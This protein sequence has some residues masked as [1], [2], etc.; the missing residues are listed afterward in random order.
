MALTAGSLIESGDIIS[1]KTR[2]KAEMAR[3]NATGSLAS[4]AT[5]FTDSASIGDL[6]KASHYNETVGYIAKIKTVT[7]LNDAVNAGDLIEAIDAAATRLTS[8]EAYSKTASSTDC[9]S[10]CTGLCYNT[11][12][13]TCR[14]C[15]SCSGSCT[16]CSG[17]SG[18]CTSCSGC[19]GGCTSCSG[20]SGCSGCTNSCA[21]WCGG[22]CWI[23]Y[24]YC[25]ASYY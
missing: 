18:G 21:S 9:A 7:G 14:G 23:D 19:S 2:V 10:S 24:C 20:C 12:T 6:A 11:C 3:R 17:C 1:L 25:N 4:F 13:G 16:S 8:N 15:S 5:N 22:S